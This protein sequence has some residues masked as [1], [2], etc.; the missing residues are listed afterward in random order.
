MPLR[1]FARK[2]TSMT[3]SATSNG[4]MSQN[5]RG[6]RLYKRERARQ[7]DEGDGLQRRSRFRNSL[8]RSL[9]TRSRVIVRVVRDPA[10]RRRSPQR[11]S[12]NT[13]GIERQRFPVSLADG[14]TE[15]PCAWPSM[16]Y[17]KKRAG[18][19]TKAR[20]QNVRHE[21]SPEAAHAAAQERDRIR[22]VLAALE[23]RQAE[24]LLLRSND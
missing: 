2:R 15:R 21:P 9:R 12:G 7:G 11:C 1:Q 22:L 10:R 4:S 3:G 14:F 6:R 23:S 20:K 24:L 5:R 13:G 16:N 8:S 19:D 17:E 18:S